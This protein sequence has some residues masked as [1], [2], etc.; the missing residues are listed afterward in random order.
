MWT[1]TTSL[2]CSL[3][4]GVLAEAIT[5]SLIK[6]ETIFL[7]EFAFIIGF[8]CTPYGAPFKFL[9]AHQYKEGKGSSKGTETMLGWLN[10]SLKSTETGMSFQLP[11]TCNPNK[12]YV[13]MPVSA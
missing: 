10:A 3:A 6:L 13:K 12:S 5:T 9:P 8:S 1:K 11:C 7:E 4:D 2:A